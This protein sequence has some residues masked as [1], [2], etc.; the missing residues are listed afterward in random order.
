MA[1][2]GIYELTVIL[3]IA[4]LIFGPARLPK[5]GRAIGDTIREFR[6]VGKEIERE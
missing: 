6:G 2:L 4:A 3:A 1:H 5:L